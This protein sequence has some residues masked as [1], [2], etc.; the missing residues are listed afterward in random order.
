[1]R[2]LAVKPSE[3]GMAKQ[4]PEAA[5]LDLFEDCERIVEA[6]MTRLAVRF[7]GEL[8]EDERRGFANRAD[9]DRP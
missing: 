8:S 9:M 4:R 6:A 2:G 1:M 5:E 7:G 3:W